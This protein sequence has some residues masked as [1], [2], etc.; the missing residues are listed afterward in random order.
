MRQQFL[1]SKVLGGLDPFVLTRSQ[2]ARLRK[3]GLAIPAKTGAGG[4]GKPKSEHHKARIAE[5]MNRH[6]ATYG[7]WKNPA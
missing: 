7:S 2:R 1:L 6:Y 4:K 5:G 3:M